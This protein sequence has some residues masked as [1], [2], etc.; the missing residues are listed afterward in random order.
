LEYGIPGRVFCTIYEKYMF[1]PASWQRYGNHFKSKLENP[2]RI[3][4]KP[5]K[6]K[7]EMKTS[8]NKPVNI[9]EIVVCFVCVFIIIKATFKL[10]THF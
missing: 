8:Y 3:I 9:D 7:V 1:I 10:I 5:V 4:I 6:S 2:E